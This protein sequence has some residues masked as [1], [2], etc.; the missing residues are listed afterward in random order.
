[1]QILLSIKPKYVRSIFTGTKSFEFRKTLFKNRAVRKALIYSSAPEKKIVGSFEI[2]DI[3]KKNPVEL[4]K[5]C[6]YKAGISEEEFFKYFKGKEKGYAIEI[7]SVNKFLKKVDPYKE[8][9]GF[10]PPQSFYYFNR[11][12][13]PKKNL[14]A[15][16][17]I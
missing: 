2:G 12:L 5:I 15:F 1:M 17:D 9:P 3:I 10:R 14:D 11:P 13:H 6:K 7:L 16:I 8:I 4:W